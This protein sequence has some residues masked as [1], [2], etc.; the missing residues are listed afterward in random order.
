MWNGRIWLAVP[1]LFSV[2][3]ML[4][5][6]IGG[7]TGVML[8]A[9]PIDYQA[10]DTYFIVAHFHYTMFGGAVFGIFAAIYFWFPKMTGV[11][12]SEKVGRGVFVLLF[13][14][15]NLTFWPQFVLGQRGMPRRYVDYAS[16]LG[17]DTPNLVSTIGAYV[18]AVGILLFLWDVW[19]SL[20]RRTPAGEDPWGGYSLEWATT[21]PPPEYNFDHLPRIRSERP[22]FDL[23]HPELKP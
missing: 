20:R 16:D 11:M 3:F 22:A 18:M 12:L 21:S 7:V 8:A 9:P 17:Y 15:F 14:G 19:T 1:M 23:H 13:A 2:G 10:Q 5:F 6:L 4:N